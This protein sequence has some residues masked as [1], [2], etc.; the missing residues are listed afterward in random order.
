MNNNIY[1]NIEDTRIT[2]SE[3][4]LPSHANFSGK[5]H[6]GY[7][8]KLMDQIAFACA[9]KHSGTYCVTASVDTVNFINP[10]EVGELVTMKASINYV[11]KTSMVVGI[12]VEAQNIQTG[13]T[14]HCNSSYFTM[15]AKKDNGD[16]AKV[17]GIIINDDNEMRRFLEAIHRIK[18]KKNRQEKFDND[19]F[20]A[21]N[22]IEELKNYNVKIE[23]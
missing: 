23:L 10:I 1:R 3:L 11:G 14:K 16:N 6:G 5:I 15:V 18:M 17:P 22:Y 9:S 4:M 8:L 20:T 13:K 12:R 2:I 19:N 21:Q 7:I